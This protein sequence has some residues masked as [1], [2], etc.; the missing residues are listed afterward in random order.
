MKNKIMTTIHC[1]IYAT[2]LAL[3]LATAL[4]LGFKLHSII[5]KFLQLIG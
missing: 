5:S 4:Y 1:M 3:T 2:F